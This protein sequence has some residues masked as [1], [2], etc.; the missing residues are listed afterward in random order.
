[1]SVAAFLVAR[2]RELVRA[3]R[4]DGNKFDFSF[5]DEDDGCKPIV[6]SFASSEAKRFDDAV[7]YLKK[8][9]IHGAAQ[10]RRAG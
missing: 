2:G 4:L 6:L 10:G 8:L 3:Q 5:R 9:T 1:M 7:L